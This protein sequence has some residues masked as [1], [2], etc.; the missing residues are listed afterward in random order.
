MG[1]IDIVK[2]LIEHGADVNV[3]SS[4]GYTPLIA[5]ASEDRSE[6]ARYLIEHGAAVDC[7]DA[8]GETPLSLACSL[9]HF[10]TTEVLLE[11]GAN[12]N[13]T[14]NARRTPMAVAIDP[15]REDGVRGFERGASDDASL[16]GLVVKGMYEAAKKLMES[17]A[18]PNKPTEVTTPPRA[19]PENFTSRMG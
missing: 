15:N 8:S 19:I 17:G 13:V 6:I 7:K 1:H 12:T 4:N 14:S 16:H 2:L 3:R 5:A 9:G 10:K 11:Y 18:D